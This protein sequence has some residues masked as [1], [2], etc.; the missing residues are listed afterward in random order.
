MKVGISLT[1]KHIKIFIAVCDTGSMTAAAKELFIAQPAVSFA[2]AE[3]ENYYGQKL[4]DR[5]SNRLYITQAGQTLLGYGRK[6]VSLFDE[7]DSEVRHLNIGGT[8]RVGFGNSFSG[9]FL[10]TI[11][12]KIQAKCTQANIQVSVSNSAIVESMLLDG[13]LDI[14]L[15]EGPVINK[16]IASQK[17][18]N[19]KVLFICPPDHPWNNKTISVDD[20]N[21]SS[22]VM[23]ERGFTE[24]NLLEKMLQTHKLKVNFVWQSSSLESILSAVES[25]M[26]ISVI[27]FFSGA[28]K[29]QAS[30]IGH[31]FLKDESIE[32][33]LLV[34][35]H[36]NKEL[37]DCMEEFQL[38]CRE[39]TNQYCKNMAE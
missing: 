22:F 19:R 18:A 13:K 2:I 12:Q 35:T 25:G 7:M 38:I 14:A 4:F 33:D 3:L 27:S 8:L 16:Y 5:I 21:G 26:G 31:F 10:H 28:A 1:L 36:Q 32:R 15:I 11:V 30:K 34:I 24:R 9:E 37:S 20:L 17:I 23:W 6:I 39:E 29:L